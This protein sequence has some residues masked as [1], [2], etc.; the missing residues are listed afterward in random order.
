MGDETMYQ[1]FVQAF[2]ANGT[3]KDARPFVSIG[4]KSARNIAA[5]VDWDKMAEIAE[6]TRGYLADV[7]A[8]VA[9]LRSALAKNP[10]TMARRAL[11]FGIA[12]P[13][14]DAQTS[15][16]WALAAEPFYGKLDAQDVARMKYV[17]L[18]TGNTC[19]MG[20]YTALEDSVRDCEA[21]FQTL[22][23]ADL[24]PDSLIRVRGIS[25]KVARMITAVADPDASVF[26][27][28]MWHARQLLWAAGMDYVVEVSVGALGYATLESLWL[29]YS[30]RFFPG[31]PQWVV[32]WATWDAANG[33]HESHRALWADLI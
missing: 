32:Q 23:L 2:K 1:D 31:I 26:T 9:E 16:G 27:V 25:N 14:R 21:I 10:A 15:I 18:V 22:T 29:D 13:K 19:R 17:S 30:A 7:D 8:E 5:L 6:H 28:D 33:Q 11:L 20:N 24:V 3:K 12:T 4:A